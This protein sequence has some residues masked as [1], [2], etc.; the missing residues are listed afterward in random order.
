MALPGDRPP[1]TL[2]LTGYSQFITTWKTDN[3]GTS[4][5]N[6]ITIPGVG[7]YTVAWEEVGNAANNGTV[8]ATNLITITFPSIGTYKIS[9]TGNLT[10]IRFGNARDRLKLLT[11]EKWGNA[12]WTSME[13]A[14][15]GCENLTYNATDAPDLSLVTSMASMF[16]S[17]TNFNGNI[18]NWNTSKVTDMNAMFVAAEMF[19]QPIGNWNTS[20][21]INMNNMFS[22]AKV[23]NQPIGNWNT[24]NVTDM[25]NM[26]LEATAFNQ[27]LGNWNVSK[28][29]NMR[30]MFA[31]ASA[32]N[33]PIGNWDVGEV[34][35]MS[36]LFEGARTFNQPIGNWNTS[37]VTNMNAL[38]NNSL[39]FNQDISNWNTQ[40][41]T[42][43][44]AMFRSARAFNQPIGSWNTTQVTDMSVMF[45]F[46]RAFNQPIGNWNTSKVTNMNTM[47]RDAT[48][49]NQNINDWDVSKVTTMRSMF[50]VATKFNQPLN[51]WNVGQVQD[52]ASM[53]DGATAFNQDIGNWD[54][55]NVVGMESMFQSALNFDQPIGNWNTSKVIHMFDMFKSASIFNQDI[56]SWNTQNVTLMNRMFLS[57]T[58]FDHPLGNWD[59]TKVTSMD[60]MLENSGLSRSNYDQTLIGWAAQNVQS[61]VPLGVTG[62]KYCSAETSRNTLA[63]TKTW[64]ITGDTKDCP[65][66][67]IEIQVDGNIV[68]SGKTVDF[69]TGTGI[70]KTFTINNIGTTTTLTLSNVPIVGVSSGTA[71]AVTE[72]PSGASIAPGAS[73]TFKVT[74]TSATDNDS[75]ALSIASNDPAQATYSIQLKG[76]VQKT[77]QT[78]NFILGSNATKAVGD[79]AFDLTATGG[80]S[81]N[82]ITFTSSNANVA[83]ISGNTV[84]VVGAGTTTITASQAGNGSYNAAP[85]VTQTLTVNKGAQ[86]I[87]FD[88]S[89]DATKAFGDANFDL[90]ATGGGPGNAVTFTSSDASV[91]TISGNTV[92]IVGVGTTTITAS[93]AGNDDYN[94]ANSVTQTLTV[95]KANQTIA[96]DLGNDATK[97]L[98]DANFDL[99][100][101]GGASGNAVTFTSSNTGVATISGNTV[102]IVGVGTTTITASQAGNAHYNAATVT[103]TLTVQSTVTSL[104]QQLKVGEVTV[105]PNPVSVML[106]I[107]ITQPAAASYAEITLLNHQGKKVLLMGKMIRNGELE[108]PV[109]QLNAGEYLLQISTGGKT[110]VRRVTKL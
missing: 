16:Q 38:F 15:S 43:M 74:Y 103:Q 84:T 97:T 32:F 26:F 70:V 48:A 92:T 107:K 78:I 55:Q 36:A 106:K 57:A 33:Q 47:F 42:N 28:V 4:N 24:G 110:I 77:D 22:R 75:G 68:T 62:L 98:G 37:K 13:K 94:A 11:I 45:G 27:P 88:L 53:F 19:N 51:N 105:F 1:V 9:I 23:F 83:T 52:M 8:N 99:T 39:V 54:T 61:N 72:Q 3:P 25:S 34:T 40:N 87:T 71:F 17:C 60:A 82:P 14:F 85:D 102:T 91:A 76:Q 21:V 89:N 20:K 5:N 2:S 96:F 59:V 95:N 79:A 65:A 64:N 104:P 81:G 73:L 101:T 93:Q 7:T 10:Q 63:N 66:I 35:N 46:T 108:I 109:E 86:T 18:G 29:V 58:A 50:Q 56:S 6:Q 67:G 90:T 30:S 44:G 69:G 49:F 31:G 100:A 80:A 41:V 12:A